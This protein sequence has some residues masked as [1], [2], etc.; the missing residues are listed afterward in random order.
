MSF[1]PGKIQ[2]KKGKWALSCTTDA[3]LVANQA[4][5]PSIRKMLEY[6]DKR[7]VTTLLVSGAV[8]PYG[9]KNVPTKFGSLS[10]GAGKGKGK[11]IGDYAYQFD[12]MGRIQRPSTIRQQSGASTAQGEFE[13]YMGDNYL[14]PGMIALFNGQGFQA[15]V[16]AMP[17]GSN[18]SYLY[19]FQSISGE[20]F[21]WSTHVAAQGSITTCMGVYSSYSE[22][23]KRGYS[24]NHFPDTF[25]NHTT[26]QRKTQKITG[27]AASNVLWLEYTNKEGRKSRG[28][29][30]EAIRQGNAQLAME[31][32]FAKLHGISSMKSTVDGSLLNE[33]R[34]GDDETGFPIIMGDGVIEQIA[35]GNESF[36]SGVNGE[37]TL[38]DFTDMMTTLEKKS[39]SL[40]EINWVCVTGTDGYANAQIQMQ[41]LAASQNVVISQEVTQT[42]AI[43]GA[44]VN[45]GFN[46]QSFNIN[47]NQIT[48]VKHPMWDDES[49]FTARGADG[50]ILQSSMYLF[51]AMGSDMDQNFEILTKGA[52]GVSRGNVTTY[53]NG[54]SGDPMMIQ[55]EEDLIKHATLKEDMAIIYNTTCCGII[56]KTA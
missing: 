55:S 11:M 32:E 25:I 35:G 53:I 29:M 9:V 46:Y 34:L 10:N 12:V 24:R 38:D 19:R 54:M 18:G 37:A 5:H 43:G 39:N 22:G 8:G 15:R 20:V 45:V 48:F 16:M 2:V 51:L 14:Y 40:G 52:N 47:G 3:D 26:I 28:W 44:N 1:N 33:S 42:G 41:A 13:L 36:G 30:F 23:S 56:N 50:K 7:M 21:D 27:T 4:K 6:S 49:R 17:T 31:D